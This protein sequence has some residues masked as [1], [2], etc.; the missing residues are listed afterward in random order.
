MPWGNGCPPRNNSW[1]TRPGRCFR[2]SFLRVQ[3]ST[4]SG[5]INRFRIPAI[6]LGLGPMKQ[7]D[8]LKRKETASLLWCVRKV[9]RVGRYRI[10]K[11]LTTSETYQASKH[12]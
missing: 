1:T 9:T 3:V 8:L 2:T 10:G 11:F 4:H 7:A 5:E 12:G 6:R